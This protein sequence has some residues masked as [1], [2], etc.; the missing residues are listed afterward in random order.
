MRLVQ[1]KILGGARSSGGANRS[2]AALAVL[3]VKS[4]C[5]VCLPQARGEALM[6]ARGAGA[7]NRRTFARAIKDSFQASGKLIQINELHVC[8]MKTLWV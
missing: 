3:P 5:A 2:K 6:A 8:G 7:T 4:C 1:L